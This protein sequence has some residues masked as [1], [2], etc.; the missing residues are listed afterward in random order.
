MSHDPNTPIDPLDPAA[1]LRT[2]VAKINEIID[3]L[4]DMWHPEPPPA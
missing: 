4:N 1:D 2:A 3:A